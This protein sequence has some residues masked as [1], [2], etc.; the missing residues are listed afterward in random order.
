MALGSTLRG[1]LITRRPLCLSHD[2]NL[3]FCPC[4]NDV[5]IYSTVSG[6]H[7]ATLRGHEGE[8]TGVCLDPSNHKQVS[9]FKL[10]RAT[11]MM[12]HAGQAADIGMHRTSC[13]RGM[14]AHP[15]SQVYTS[16]VDGTLRLWDF[17]EGSQ[18]QTY[19]LEEPIEQL[20]RTPT[21][22]ISSR[23]V[24]NVSHQQVHTLAAA[25]VV[26]GLELALSQ[27]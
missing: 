14:A 5:R 7:I 15:E 22:P 18:L 21:S 13:C 27:P 17:E 2:G 19:P 8:V 23:P 24:L 11:C 4:A 26:V 10:L 20:V 9:S 25:F 1:G 6:D 3:F 12:A 16:S